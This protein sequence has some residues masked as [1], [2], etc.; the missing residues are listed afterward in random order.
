MSLLIEIKSATTGEQPISPNAA[1]GQTFSAFTKVSQT[2]FVHGLVDKN[3]SPEPY[4]VRISIDL[5]TKER[6]FRPAYAPGQYQID[7]GSF[8]VGR[9]DDLSLGSLLLSPV[10][11]ADVRKI[12]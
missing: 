4:P 2:A 10:V 9:F 3:G 7:S 8:F 11:A 1:K 5:G 6:G 12:A